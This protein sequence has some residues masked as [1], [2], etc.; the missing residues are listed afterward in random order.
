M[1]TYGSLHFSKV[2]GIL[3]SMGQAP[4]V[5]KPL[6]FKLVT[7]SKLQFLYQPCTLNTDFKFL[8]LQF[9]V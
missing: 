9:L 4:Q 5:E 8:N 2:E 6:F 3:M 7:G 1:K